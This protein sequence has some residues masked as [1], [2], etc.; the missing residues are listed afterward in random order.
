MS[1]LKRKAG[2]E[3]GADP[4]KAKQGSIMTFFGAPKPSSGTGA[5]ADGAAAP[6]PS[7]IKFDKAKWVA[8]LNPEQRRLLQLEIDTLHESWL[9]LL[10]DELVTKEFLDL[11]RFLEREAAAGKKIF[12]PKEDIYSWYVVFSSFLLNQHVLS[13][14]FHFYLFFFNPTHLD[15]YP[16]SW[17]LDS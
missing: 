17:R 8:S 4:K 13:R 3:A 12:P 5:G 9:G 16:G 1:T 2:T 15:G 10:K 11:K 6:E 7:P 14:F